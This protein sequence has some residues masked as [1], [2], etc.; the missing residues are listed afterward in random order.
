M[1]SQKTIIAIEQMAVECG[2]VNENQQRLMRFNIDQLDESPSRL[3]KHKNSV[4]VIDQN[5]VFFRF[6][7]DGVNAI[8]LMIDDHQFEFIIENQIETVCLFETTA[9][10]LDYISSQIKFFTYSQNQQ[11][12]Q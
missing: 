9:D 11:I 10:M 5:L 4:L 3:L 8:I 6:E 7:N 2:F 12:S 1:T